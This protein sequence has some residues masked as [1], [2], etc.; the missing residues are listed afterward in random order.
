LREGRIVGLANHTRL[1]AK[2]GR[3]IPIDDSAAPIRDDSKT[4]GVVMVFRD[5]AE[6]LKAEE[7]LRLAVE[8]APNAMIMVS[9]DGRIEL[10]N[11]QTKKLFGYGREE[12]VGQTIEILVPEHYRSGHGSLRS[13][14]FAAPSARPMG[15]GR[16]LFG[17]RRDGSEV[18][19]EIGLNPISTVKETSF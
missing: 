1:V 4:T 7:R 16:D 15:A 14:F 11:S 18:P 6:R 9:R 19:I 13:S 8:A 10:V 17:L 5:I 2:D 3:E 12:L